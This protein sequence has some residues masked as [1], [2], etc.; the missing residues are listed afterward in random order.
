M[1]HINR[2]CPKGRQAMRKQKEKELE[3]SKPKQP[4][5]PMYKSVSQSAGNLKWQEQAWNGQGGEDI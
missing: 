3:A 2:I 1:G 4:K 5:P